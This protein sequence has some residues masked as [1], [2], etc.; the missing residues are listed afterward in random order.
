MISDLGCSPR[1]G[2][3]YLVDRSV[4]W[5][6]W[7]LQ[8]FYLFVGFIQSYE[9]QQISFYIGKLHHNM[10]GVLELGLVLYLVIED[11]LVAPGA[12]L[13]SFLIAVI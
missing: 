7:N 2:V 9:V 1:M 12:F 8:R 10:A 4:T 3:L 5:S 6:P 11:H 13:V